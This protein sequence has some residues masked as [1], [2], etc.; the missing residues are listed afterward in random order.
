MG[1]QSCVRRLCLRDMNVSFSID[2]YDVLAFVTGCLLMTIFLDW[3]NRR[4]GR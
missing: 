4:Y 3:F 1:E 2:R